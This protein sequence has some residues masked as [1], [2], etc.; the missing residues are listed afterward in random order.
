VIKKLAVFI[1]GLAVGIGAAVSYQMQFGSLPVRPGA[2]ESVSTGTRSAIPVASPATGTGSSVV[3]ALGTIEPKGGIINVASP[4]VGHR[5][6]KI[7]VAEGVPVNMNDV[8]VELD[9]SLD[10]KEMQLVDIQLAEAK[11]RQSA[12]V[13]RAQQAL[14][15]AARA[16]QILQGSRE[17]DLAVQDA[18]QKVL[19]AKAKQAATDLTRLRQLRQLSDPPVSDQQVEQ[20]AVLVEVAQ[21]EQQAG[22]VGVKKLKQSLDFQIINAEAEQKAAKRMLD[23]ATAGAGIRSL[24]MQKEL[25]GLKLKQS[26]ITAPITGTVLS[27]PAH[28]G[29]VVTQSPLLR[30]ADLTEIVCKVEVDATD[31][32]RLELG[33][34][35][36]V[37]CRAFRGPFPETTVSGTIERFG[38][39]VAQATIQPMDPRK[40]VDRHV[41]EVIVSLNAEEVLKRIYGTKTPDATALVGLQV[42]ARFDEKSSGAKPSSP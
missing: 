14:E 40:P 41:V 26:T 2:A 3:V 32:Q 5:I 38:S 1:V 34:A 23:L 9:K 24:E 29:E 27:V 33:E 8:V 18:R 22:D 42:E 30:M 13:E 28:A 35:A 19:A 16:L 10:Q 17:L 12:E 15:A 37:A 39:V 6:E 4:L 7:N 20:Q 11:D 36:K 31:V 21:A 25:T